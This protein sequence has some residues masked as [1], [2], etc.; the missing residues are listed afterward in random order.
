MNIVQLVALCPD[1]GSLSRPPFN[2]ENIE[3]MQ[4]SNVSVQC[5]FCGGMARLNDGVFSI[6]K[7]TIEVIK[8]GHVTK[9]ILLK[10]KDLV[11]KAQRGD[12]T[13]DEFA[14]RANSINPLIGELVQKS[15]GKIA[16]ATLLL[17]LLIILQ[18][19]CSIDINFNVNLDA[20][21]LV[22]QV[23]GESPKQPPPI[24]EEN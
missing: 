14:I 24:A 21:Q 4:I 22:E 19:S 20:N 6:A 11:E 23:I 13:F 8:A 18:K 3:V 17:M 7:D 2:F 12:M 10:M 9:E 16:F 5:P 15:R 1:C